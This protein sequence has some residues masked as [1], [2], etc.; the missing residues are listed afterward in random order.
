[1]KVTAWNNGGLG[2]GI[3]I[4]NSDRSTYFSKKWKHVRVKI[5]RN[6]EAA[7]PLTACF[8]GERAEIRGTP[9]RDW[10][11]QLGHVKNGRKKWRRG[12]P[13][14]FNLTPMGGNRFKLSKS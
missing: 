11:E 6:P 14:Q 3:K 1:M 7:F 5:P 12:R 10:F 4:G 8:W 13:P 2:Y 9:F